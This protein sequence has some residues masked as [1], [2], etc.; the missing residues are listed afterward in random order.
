LE[1]HVTRTEPWPHEETL[2]RIRRSA[3]RAARTDEEA[4]KIYHAF[5]KR[6]VGGRV[7]SDKT[8]VSLEHKQTPPGAKAFLIIVQPHEVEYLGNPPPESC[9]QHGEKIFF[10]D[11]APWSEWYLGVVML[12]EMVHWYDIVL[13]GVE[14]PGAARDSDAYVQGEVHAHSVESRV[15]NGLTKGQWHEGALAVLKNSRMCRK[16]IDGFVIPSTDGI[17]A[18]LSFLPHPPECRDEHNNRNAAALTEILFAQCADD[19][20]RA[21]AYRLPQKLGPNL[22]EW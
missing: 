5:D 6:S 22:S 10:I 1:E 4:Q 14:Q 11:R 19:T 3:R 21:A 16:E 18:L 9:F 2:A 8:I 17:D 20:A 12:H 7:R 15:L 13:T